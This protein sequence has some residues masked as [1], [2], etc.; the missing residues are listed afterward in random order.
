MQRVEDFADW[1]TARELDHLPAEPG[2]VAAYLTWLAAERTGTRTV[3]GRGGG[4][5][6]MPMKPMRPAS[7]RKV[8]SAI[9]GAHQRAGLADP[10]LHPAIGEVL[11]GIDRKHR[12]GTVKRAH[13]AVG[14]E[15]VKMLSVDPEV[16]P[17]LAAPLR[18][19]RD[20]AVLATGYACAMRRSEIVALDVEDIERVHRPSTPNVAAIVHIRS[21]KT[22]QPGKGMTRELGPVPLG[23]MDAWLGL[24]VIRSGAIFRRIHGRETLG[25]RLSDGW[26]P[27]AFLGD[28]RASAVDRGRHH[29]RAPQLAVQ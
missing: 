23:I 26:W 13:A 1:C 20:L 11:D 3:A 28:P 10:T 25:A 24:A 27:A 19:A 15:I 6:Q 5:R 2:I 4:V 21:S 14:D 17:E 16:D 9:R 8:V 22:D 29:C 12:G 7:I 18:R